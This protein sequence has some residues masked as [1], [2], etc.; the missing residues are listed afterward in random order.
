MVITSDFKTFANSYHKNTG[1]KYLPKLPNQLIMDI[2]KLATE[3]ERA[4]HKSKFCRVLEDYMEAELSG[5]I[6]PFGV[7]SAWDGS[8]VDQELSEVLLEEH[9]DDFWEGSVFGRFIF[10]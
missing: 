5:S 1:G 6:E 3:L 7:E 2:I 8:Y 4:A 9:P 10:C